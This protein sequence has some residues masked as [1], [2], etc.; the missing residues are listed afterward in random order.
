M[1]YSYTF[2]YKIVKKNMI[3]VNA[4]KS[5][6]HLIN[7]LFDIFIDFIIKLNIVFGEFTPV[8]NIFFFFNNCLET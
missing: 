5:E 6:Y 8:I 3:L 2:D 4:L 1:E 7:Q